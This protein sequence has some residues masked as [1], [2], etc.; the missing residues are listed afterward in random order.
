[1]ECQICMEIKPGDKVSC[2]SIVPHNLCF[3]CEHTWRSKMPLQGGVRIMNCP[4]CRQPEQY[5]TIE[6]L[7][8]DSVSELI[9][10][11]TEAHLLSIVRASAT[12]RAE[13]RSQPRMPQPR[14][15]CSGR[16]CRNT[17]RTGRARMTYLKCTICRE[18][19]CCRSC[20][21]CMRCRP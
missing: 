3:D 4:T 17:S 21:V 20:E 12:A 13:L 7:Q 16:D 2:G 10:M 19:F 18:I 15:S 6:S 5:R 9:A 14:S 1:M 8:R 11:S